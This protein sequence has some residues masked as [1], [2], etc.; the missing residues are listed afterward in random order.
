M[1]L[2]ITALFF[3]S[4]VFGQ[5][6]DKG[7]TASCGPTSVNLDVEFSREQGSYTQP[8]LNGTQ[9]YFVQDDEY[10]GY[11][12][13]IGLDG[14]WVGANKNDSYFSLSVALGEHHLCAI[15]Q[16]KFSAG[17]QMAFAHFSAEAGRVLYFRTRFLGGVKSDIPPHLN[18]ELIDSDEAR[19][20]IATSSASISQ[21]KK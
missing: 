2:I 7:V 3:A 10:P 14:T 21:S 18:L 6:P 20:L 16:S 12:V 11:T 13:K 17:K 1:K 8:D 5:N 9:V 19:Y 15:V 4:T